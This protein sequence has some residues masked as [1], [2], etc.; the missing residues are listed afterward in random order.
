M[1][2]EQS[3]HV[4]ATEARHFGWQIPIRLRRSARLSGTVGLLLHDLDIVQ[5]GEIA[6]VNLG[7]NL[8]ARFDRLV[9]IRLV[10]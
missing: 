2:S 1:E 9:H 3:S 5:C 6:V 4:V 10:G 8:I 7:G